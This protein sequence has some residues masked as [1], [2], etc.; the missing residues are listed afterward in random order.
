MVFPDSWK[1]KMKRDLAKLAEHKSGR[2][3]LGSEPHEDDD[4]Q[5]NIS[6]VG[7]EGE[8]SD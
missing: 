1:R 4:S 5:P 6:I 8:K 2:R 3:L 7:P